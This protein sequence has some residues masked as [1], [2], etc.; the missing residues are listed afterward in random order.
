M[1]ATD[2][3]RGLLDIIDGVQTQENPIVDYAEEN[4]ADCDMDEIAQ[5]TYSN[6][7]DEQITPT[8]TIMSI[9]NDVHKPKNPA[10]IRVSTVALYPETAYKGK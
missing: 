6:T 7:P 4:S 1:R 9:G 5:D 2:F 3:I 10:D 8:D